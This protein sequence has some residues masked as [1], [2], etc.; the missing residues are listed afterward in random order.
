M[1]TALDVESWQVVLI[2]VSTPES[3]ELCPAH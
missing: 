3:L 1:Y 2:T